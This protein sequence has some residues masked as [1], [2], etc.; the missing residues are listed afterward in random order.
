MPYGIELHHLYMAALLM[1]VFVFSFVV[2]AAPRFE[3]WLGAMLAIL[4]PGL[5]FLA[6]LS[7]VPYS[8]WDDGSMGVVLGLVTYY[9]VM[10]I[11]VL[12]GIGW[13]K[14]RFPNQYRGVST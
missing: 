8:F 9:L 11:G 13:R 14:R 5:I 7:L 6:D 1:F 4:V 12:S 10:F 3:D 2:I